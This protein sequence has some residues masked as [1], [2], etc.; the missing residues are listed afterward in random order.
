MRVFSI[1]ATLL[2]ST[3]VA[4]LAMSTSASAVQLHRLQNAYTGNGIF[5]LGILGGPTNGH[6]HDN[7]GLTVWQS[8]Q[9]DQDWWVPIENGGGAFWDFYTDPNGASLCIATPAL[10]PPGTGAPI[11]ATPCDGNNPTQQEYWELI[12]SASVNLG[13]QYPGCY[14]MWNP[15]FGQ[16][17]GVLF[18][19]GSVSDGG[20]VVAWN[21]DGSA[22][23]FWC[24]VAP[25]R[26]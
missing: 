18:G 22:N 1:K 15:Y 21:Y 19:D 4:T 24:P 13:A 23:Q 6:V 2:L 7:T 11:F 26:P 10:T 14:I 9:A 5:Y 8:S 3:V 16:A 25:I 17:I 12:S 20:E